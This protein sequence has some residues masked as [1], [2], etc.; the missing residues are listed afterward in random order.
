MTPFCIRLFKRQIIRN[1]NT[2]TI[3]VIMCNILYYNTWLLVAPAVR[4]IIDL[5]K[6]ANIDSKSKARDSPISAAAVRSSG[7]PRWSR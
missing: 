1:R 3:I 7:G 6:P 5:A 4:L 2:R